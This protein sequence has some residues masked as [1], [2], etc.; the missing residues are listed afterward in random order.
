MLLIAAAVSLVIG[1]V[2]EG[3]PGGLIEGTSIM[4]AL[5]III[6]V[7]SVN[8]YRSERK[9]AELINLAAKQEVRVWRGNN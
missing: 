1:I 7:G 4:I 9:L 8:N 2:K 6:T 3:F 5:T